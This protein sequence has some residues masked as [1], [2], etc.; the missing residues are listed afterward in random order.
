MTII[1]SLLTPRL[2]HHIHHTA[3]E[4]FDAAAEGMRETEGGGSGDSSAELSTESVLRS[5][6]SMIITLDQ[7][8][9]CAAII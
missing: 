3:Q 8:T 4:S 9:S 7:V 5:V 6:R 1:K 2:S